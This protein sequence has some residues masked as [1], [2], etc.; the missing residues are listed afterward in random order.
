MLQRAF[1][2]HRAGWLDRDRAG[3]LAC[4]QPYPGVAAA[5]AACEAPFY[6]A[7]RRARCRGAGGGGCE[8]GAAPRGRGRS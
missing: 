4:N 5:L 3:W 8:A 1:E 7:S 2:T 6:I